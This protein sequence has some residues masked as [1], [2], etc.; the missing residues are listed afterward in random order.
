M[1]IAVVIP[2]HNRVKPLQRAVASV[3]D[4]TERVQE[5]VVVDDGSDEMNA[6]DAL[7]EVADDRLRILHQPHLGVSV[8]RNLGIKATK[9][10]WV[11][12]LD[13]D[14][15]WLPEK[16]ARQKEFHARHPDLTISQTNEIW[17]R[18][19]SRI[20]QRQYHLKA[21]GDIFE[22]SLERCLISPSAVLM[23]RSL[24]D[25]VGLFDPTLPACEDYDLW[26]RV[27]SQYEVG[28]VTEELI[29]KTGGHA[30]QL[31]RRHWGMDRFR[32]QALRKV[33][34]GDL[35]SQTQRWAALQTLAAKLTILENGARKRGK[36]AQSETYRELRERYTAPEQENLTLFPSDDA[37]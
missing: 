19:G 18:D 12:L 10:A 27:T 3:L 16:I 26:L 20:N 29:V 5:I 37:L 22:Q 1:D 35:L 9:S 4:Q 33:I 11:A 25:D 6:I 7:K 36:T 8:A 28:L 13:S 23:R 21:G 2:V 31:S 30:D 15:Y 17:M 32:V 14:D 34:D 24:L